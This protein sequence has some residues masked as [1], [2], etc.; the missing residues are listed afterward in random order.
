MMLFFY[1]YFIYSI[2]YFIGHEFT[3][4]IVYNAAY[5]YYTVKKK[6]KKFPDSKFSSD[7]SHLNFFNRPK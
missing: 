6:K 7:W 4:A 1:Y 5:L 3:Y 2:S